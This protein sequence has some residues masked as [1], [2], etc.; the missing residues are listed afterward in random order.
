MHHALPPTQIAPLV[1][2]VM[3]PNG[4]ETRASYEASDDENMMAVDEDD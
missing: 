2:T 3:P 4:P 1:A